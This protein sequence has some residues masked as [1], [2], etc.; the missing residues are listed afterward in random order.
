MADD[1]DVLRGAIGQGARYLEIKVGLAPCG[2]LERL[3][4][5]HPVLGTVLA[6]LF[7]KDGVGPRWVVVFDAAV[8][9]RPVDEALGCELEG[10]TAGVG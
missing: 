6:A 10:P 4:E 1:A 8:L 2:L 7:G 5:P 3:L 9:R